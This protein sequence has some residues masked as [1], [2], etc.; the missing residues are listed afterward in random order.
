MELQNKICTKLDKLVIAM[1]CNHPRYI[2]Q[3]S[4]VCGHT[5]MYQVVCIE[6]IRE[7]ST[8][9]YGRELIQYTIL[10]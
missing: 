3:E 7:R 6:M 4:Y 9:S 2:K 1:E 8:Y 5:Y 10:V